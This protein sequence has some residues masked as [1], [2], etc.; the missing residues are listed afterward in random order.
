MQIRY[1]VLQALIAGSLSLFLAIESQMES[2]ERVI[3]RK[4]GRP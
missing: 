1:A 4:A 3:N 2:Q